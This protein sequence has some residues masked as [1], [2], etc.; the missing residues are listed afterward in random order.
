V[1]PLDTKQEFMF[2]PDLA[3]VAVELVLQDAGW[4]GA[5]NIAGSGM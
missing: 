2:T 3:A 1:G 5:Y 4:G